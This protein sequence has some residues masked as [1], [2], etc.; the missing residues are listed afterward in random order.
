MLVILVTNINLNG[1]ENKNRMHIK[2]LISILMLRYKTK[3]LKCERNFFINPI[4]SLWSKKIKD[5]LS[6]GIA[7]QTP[8]VV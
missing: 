5:M 7:K 6:E 2:L 8:W 1:C 3:Y 4:L